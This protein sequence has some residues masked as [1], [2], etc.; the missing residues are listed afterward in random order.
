MTGRSLFLLG[1]AA[2]TLAC[3]DAARESATA[4][5]GPTT[6]VAA[7]GATAVATGRPATGETTRVAAPDTVR[8]PAA[9][10]SAPA[11]PFGGGT[12]RVRVRGGEPAGPFVLRAVRTARQPGFDRLVFEFSG[13]AVPHHEVEYVGAPAQCGS[14]DAVPVDGTPLLVR[15]HGADAHAWR[16]ETM[17]PTIA[18]RDRRP[19][20]A[21][22]RR[23][24]QICDFEATVEWVMDVDRRRP[25][26][27][28]ALRDPTRVVVDV[29]A[30]P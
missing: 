23:V 22:I 5:T 27:V 26:R 15:F 21:T 30:A 18:E 25:F 14:G 16:G 2:S 6:V 9:R 3:G 4:R 13:T 24:R 19:A 11:T 29:E 12:A 1:A 8:L 17:Q 28:S 7:A 10:D 20:L